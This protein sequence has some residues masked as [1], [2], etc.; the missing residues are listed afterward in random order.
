MFTTPTRHRF[1]VPVQTYMLME[2]MG[3]P[4]GA[5]TPDPRV[6]PEAERLVESGEAE[7]FLERAWDFDSPTPD[8]PR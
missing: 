7:A 5:F 1:I 8:F 6:T 2:M 4:A 3:L